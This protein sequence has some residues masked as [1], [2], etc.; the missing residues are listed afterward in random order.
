MSSKVSIIVPIYNAERYLERCLESILGQ[1]LKEL[2]LIL[3]DDG[4]ADGS[5]NIC[6]DFA[7]KD[8]R[9]TVIHKKNGGVSSARNA[10][11]KVAT[12]EYIGF[13]DADDWCAE[14]MYQSLYDEAAETAADLALCNYC[15][16]NGGKIKEKPELAGIMPA[17]DVRNELMGRILSVNG[18]RISGT[19]CRIIVRKEWITANRI[20]FQ[21][22]YRAY[23][24]LLFTQQCLDKANKVS[25]IQ[26]CYYYRFENA[27][28]VTRNY[29]RNLHGDILGIYGE[30]LKL[31]TIKSE[32]GKYG[33]LLEAWLADGIGFILSNLCGKGSPYRIKERVRMMKELQK[34]VWI[35]NAVANIYTN[36]RLMNKSKYIQVLLIKYRHIFPLVMCH[37]VRKGT[38]FGSRTLLHRG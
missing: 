17:N 10:G 38:L 13:A 27:S 3:V 6:D 36:R 2:E 29:I 24:D 33:R 26:D 5:G 16:V 12:G 8:G 21:E 32:R 9:I 22:N 19:C 25:V 11:M 30:I 1:T 15:C 7:L 4:S 14:T 20:R 34:N 23:E 18:T 37:S 31:N 28:S 35:K